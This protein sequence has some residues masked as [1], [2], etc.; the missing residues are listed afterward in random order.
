[1]YKR[2][3]PDYL[4][5]TSQ[6]FLCCKISSVENIMTKFFLIL[7]KLQRT[8]QYFRH[9]RQFQTTTKQ[10]W[11]TTECFPVK[12]LFLSS[13]KN[14]ILN[15]VQI[16]LLKL[17]NSQMNLEYLN[18]L[19]SPDGSESCHGFTDILQPSLICAS[20][21]IYLCA[22]KPANIPAWQWTQ[23][24]PWNGLL[25][26]LVEISHVCINLGWEA[27]F[28]GPCAS[29]ASSLLLDTFLWNYCV[30][31]WFCRLQ[32]SDCSITIE[33]PQCVYAYFSCVSNS[34]V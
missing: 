12:L 13:N 26:S 29:V 18:L 34:W 31:S 11:L 8:S 23:L 9:F 3:R 32:N 5:T 30:F 28:Y 7:Y 24:G 27:P 15:G 16:R 2:W 20:E 19:C 33:R 17:P 10:L 6:H 25:Q 14:N 1:M 22:H 21:L 4:K